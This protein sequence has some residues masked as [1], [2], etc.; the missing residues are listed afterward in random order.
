MNYLTFGQFKKIA[1]EFP[2][3]IA[4]IYG[5]Q[6][7]TYAELNQKANAIANTLVSCGVKTWQSR[8]YLYRA[9]Y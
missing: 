6:H 2:E 5:N 7:V 4:L 3:E 8:C 1:I 9:F